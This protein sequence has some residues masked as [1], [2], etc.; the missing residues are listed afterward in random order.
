MPARPASAPA[1]AHVVRLQLHSEVI[2]V[3]VYVV[4]SWRGQH[5]QWMICTSHAASF[6]P[7][8]HNYGTASPRL[9][10]RI[11]RGC[12]ARGMVLRSA[13]PLAPVQPWDHGCL[14]WR[15]VFLVSPPVLKESPPP[16]FR[17][18]PGGGS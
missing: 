2:G 3:T 6:W 5:S 14:K 18:T 1:S 10:M 11:L 16:F 9:S 8:L 7:S 4:R 12:R 15:G 13:H 17:S